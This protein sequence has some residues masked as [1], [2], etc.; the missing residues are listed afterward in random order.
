MLGYKHV[1]EG[2]NPGCKVERVL[3]NI[4]DSAVRGG[5]GERTREQLFDS[6]ITGVRNVTNS[7]EEEELTTWTYLFYTW[8]SCEFER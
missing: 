6:A 8:Q 5:A 2:V 7:R 1:K 3:G 4:A